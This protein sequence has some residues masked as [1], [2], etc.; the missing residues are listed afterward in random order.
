MLARAKSARS[1]KL[2]SEKAA[3][4]AFVAAEGFVSATDVAALQTAV[5]A[6]SKTG[7]LLAAGTL[8]E[9]KTIARRARIRADRRQHS[10][11]RPDLTRAP[12]CFPARSGP[13]VADVKRSAAAAGAAAQA[14][15]AAL[16][17]AVAALD[18]AASLPQA[19]AD[20]VA[21]VAALRD[22]VAASGVAAKITGL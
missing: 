2:A 10:T 4:R 1:S 9:A 18:R 20:Y 16:L 11:T 21:A 7:S 6:L 19:K 14:S 15:S 5:N 22:L 17:T 13:W 3:Q 12:L 8:D